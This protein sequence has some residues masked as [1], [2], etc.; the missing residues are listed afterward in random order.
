MTEVKKEAENKKYAE[1]AEKNEQPVNNF[2]S[3]NKTVNIHQAN[4]GRT[5]VIEGAQD[6]RPNNPERQEIDLEKDASIRSELAEALK[7]LAA[8][9]KE[10]EA[11]RG[12][13]TDLDKK[14]ADLNDT[15]QSLQNNQV[16][17]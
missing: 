1:A 10:K 15:N 13:I 5:P 2:I 17:N 11:L 14:I 16:V 8:E 7:K 3:N 6:Q 4:Q 9:I 12:Q